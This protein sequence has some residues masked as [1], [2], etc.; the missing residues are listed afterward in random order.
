MV[1]PEVESAVVVAVFVAVVV[2]VVD[3]CCY[4][5]LTPLLLSLLLSCGC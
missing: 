4:V 5:M 3:G 1:R 2:A